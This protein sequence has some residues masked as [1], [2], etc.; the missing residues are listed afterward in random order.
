M[1]RPGTALRFK[2]EEIAN[3]DETGLRVFALIVM[4]L[5]WRGAKDVMI[6][7]GL[8]NKLCLS[9]VII[10]YGD[11]TMD[12]VV[13]W[14]SPNSTKLEWSNHGAVFPS[15]YGKQQ[16][17]NRLTRGSSYVALWSTAMVALGSCMPR[18]PK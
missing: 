6:D 10:W 12:L 15:Y 4:T 14:T 13:V 17:C 5:H 2:E 11:G 16:H 3:L 7:K 18:I 1:V 8:T 9:I